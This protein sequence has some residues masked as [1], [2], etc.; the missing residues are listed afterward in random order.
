MVSTEVAVEVG[1]DGF[2]AFYARVEPQLRRALMA[3]H[4]PEVRAGGDG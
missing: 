3:A 4:G 1:A 2:V